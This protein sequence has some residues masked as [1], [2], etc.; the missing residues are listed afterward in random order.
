MLDIK[1]FSSDLIDSSLDEKLLVFKE[2]KII[3]TRYD[4]DLLFPAGYNICI[5]P[6]AGPG[7]EFWLR[8]NLSLST[9]FCMQQ[10][11]HGSNIFQGQTEVFVG[12][13][14]KFSCLLP[15]LIQARKTKV[16]CF[17]KDKKHQIYIY[18][19]AVKKPNLN[20][21]ILPNRS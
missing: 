10:L 9:S 21:D 6:G 12:C 1:Q 2:I 5:F 18:M 16:I 13:F 15:K 14:K 3:F 11:V 4:F 8:I 19:H 17:D 20:P 7:L